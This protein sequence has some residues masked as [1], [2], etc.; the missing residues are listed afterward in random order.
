MPWCWIS[1]INAFDATIQQVVKVSHWGT[2]YFSLAL[3]SGRKWRF[4]ALA[5]VICLSNKQ[6]N[7]PSREHSVHHF[8]SSHGQTG[9]PA[10][11]WQ[12]WRGNIKNKKCFSMLLMCFC[13]I[14]GS[15]SR[16]MKL[17]TVPVA[18]DSSYPA[19]LL[20]TQTSWQVLTWKKNKTNKPN[21][22]APLSYKV[23]LNQLSWSFHLTNLI[24]PNFES[25]WLQ[26]FAPFCLFWT[27]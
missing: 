5:C 21:A 15:Q 18:L 13:S 23:M 12:W 9:Y 3:S 1:G 4:K 20:L 24:L 22:Q 10:F 14:N 8:Y 17:F 26:V 27:M 6:C 2:D 25:N 11:G 19:P 7:C 16:L